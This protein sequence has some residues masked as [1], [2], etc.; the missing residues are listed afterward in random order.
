MLESYSSSNIIYIKYILEVVY[1]QR[2]ILT[3][4]N[5]CTILELVWFLA[6]SQE[7]RDMVTLLVTKVG[8]LLHSQWM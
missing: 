5:E 4:C 8:I 1:L 6:S 7:I 3:F 2:N